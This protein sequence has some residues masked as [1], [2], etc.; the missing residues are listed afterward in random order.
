MFNKNVA[1]FMTISTLMF[2]AAA[3]SADVVAPLKTDIKVMP[4]DHK[5]LP[6]DKVI[7]EKDKVLMDKE[8]VLLMDKDKGLMISDEK[9]QSDIRELLEKKF[10]G[11]ILTIK[12][13]NGDVELTGKLKDADM[14]RSIKGEVIK[15][16]GVKGVIL[17]LDK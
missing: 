11:F 17:I 13:I 8:K 1:L 15:V 14:E 2:T 3:N 12:V 6:V 16:S 10:P 7:I 9:I 5:V 4:A